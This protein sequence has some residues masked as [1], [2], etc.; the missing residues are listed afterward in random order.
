M[1]EGGAFMTVR[2]CC[3]FPFLTVALLLEGGCR[4][5]PAHPLKTS[6]AVRPPSTPKSVEFFIDQNPHEGT[7]QGDLFPDFQDYDVDLKPVSPGAFRGSVLLV[8]FWAAGNALSMAE[9]PKI[10]ALYDK[11]HLHGLEVIGISLDPDKEGFLRYLRFHPTPW[12]QYCDG[13]SWDSKLA[14]RYGILHVPETFLIG[15]DGRILA[16][17]LRGDGLNAALETVLGE[18]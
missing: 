5:T 4:K 11:Y 17:G 18:P 13:M 16:R 7:A 14:V 15:R 12:V 3:A 2:I 6:E 9:L 1:A 10:R 8:D